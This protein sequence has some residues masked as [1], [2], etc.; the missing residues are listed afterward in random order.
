MRRQSYYVLIYSVPYYLT[1]LVLT[2]IGC[3]ATPL[4]LR[5]L[6]T[7]PSHGFR[8]AMVVTLALLILLA[9]ISDLGALLGRWQGP[10]LLLRRRYD[11]DMGLGLVFL[12]ACILSGVVEVGRRFLSAH[13]SRLIRN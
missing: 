6:R 2:I 11:Y 5:R 8:D 10:V 3:G 12:P 9:L 4:I 7:S 1:G 13:P